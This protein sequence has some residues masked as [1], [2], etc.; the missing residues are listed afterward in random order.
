MMMM[1]MMMMMVRYTVNETR[2]SFSVS[3]SLWTVNCRYYFLL[4]LMSMRII[5]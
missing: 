3:P 5:Q 2:T 4:S 1:M